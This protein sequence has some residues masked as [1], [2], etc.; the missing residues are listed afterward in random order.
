MRFKSS[1]SSSRVISEEP[2]G[3]G[4]EDAAMTRVDGRLGR[5]ETV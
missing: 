5:D 2:W 3:Q 4:K 1:E